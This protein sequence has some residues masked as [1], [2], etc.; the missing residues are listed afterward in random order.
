MILNGV[1]RSTSGTVAWWLKLIGVGGVDDEG[2]S[3][4]DGDDY[5]KG[6]KRI[7][8]YCLPCISFG[9]GERGKRRVRVLTLIF[10]PLFFM[11]L[12]LLD[13]LG[14]VVEKGVRVHLQQQHGKSTTTTG[15]ESD[16]DASSFSH[17]HGDLSKWYDSRPVPRY[18]WLNEFPGI[19]REVMWTPMEIKKTVSVNDR[20]SFEA[21]YRCARGM[22]VLFHGCGRY[23]A[24]FFYSPQG[25]KIVN[26]AYDAGLSVLT[27]K[28]T[29]ELRCWDWSSDGDAVLKIGRK[30]MVSQ[31][32]DSC[33]KDANGVSIYPPVW[34]FGASS[35]GYFIAA[36]AAKMKEDP[37][38]HRPFLFSAI[39]IQIMAPPAGLI[40]D[41]PTLFTVMDGDPVTKMRVQE[42]VDGKVGG[43]GGPVKMV[44]TSGKKGIHPLHFY[45]LYRDDKRMSE[46]ISRAIYLDLVDAK[47]IDASNDDRLT[48]DPRGMGEAV[49]S[50]WKKYVTAERTLTKDEELAPP[51]GISYPL[52]RPLKAEELLDADGIWLIEE[53]NVAWDV[54]E[55]TSEG[56][57][58][59]LDFFYEFGKG[60]DSQL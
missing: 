45:D 35:G 59:V 54:H 36:L 48:A 3:D 60:G 44:T 37:D 28:K 26:A 15:S 53:L 7:T 58:G 22:L 14:K 42:L 38:A 8:F 6:K 51:L 13:D 31:L 32:K 46:E 40:W 5:G 4:D 39:N 56:F 24:S 55:I 41:I 20:T 47:I 11:S 30:F 34:A 49:T 29:N 10:F 9:A 1:L 12:F 16:P 43:G 57:E 17:P 52:V 33:G 18:K 27:F 25:R 19:T 2:D 23:A 50:V 21:T